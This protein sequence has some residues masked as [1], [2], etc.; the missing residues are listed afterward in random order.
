M[1]NEVGGKLAG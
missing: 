1:D